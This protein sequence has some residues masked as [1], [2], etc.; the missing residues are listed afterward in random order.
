VMKEEIITGLD[1]G[2][3]KV[4]TV[5][6]L[7]D[8]TEVP[9]VIGWAEGKSEGMRRGIVVDMEAVVESVRR[10]VLDAQSS[11]GCEIGSAI[12]SVSGGHLQGMDSRGVIAVSRNG[13]EITRRDVKR[14]LEAAGTMAIP[15]DRE[16]LHVI[17]QEFTLDYQRGIRDPVGMSG[18]RLE[19]EVHLIK[20]NHRVDVGEVID[21]LGLEAGPG[22]ELTIEASGVEAEA[23]VDELVT[24]LESD[25]RE[26]QAET[27]KE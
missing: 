7:R 10:V 3:T 19:A 23:A 21:I 1:V 11:A 2:A 17:E 14:V 15:N 20:Q 25:F 12:V 27:P 13:D 9:K 4:C 24:L 16:V 18:I 22:E 6:A 26:A 5:M 8:D